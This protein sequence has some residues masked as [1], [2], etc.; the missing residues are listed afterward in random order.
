MNE[1]FITP[2]QLLESFSETNKI[3]MKRE[4]L[5][6]FSFG[7]NKVRIA[8]S[9]IKDMK[10]RG[11]DSIITYGSS[12]SNLSRVMANLCQ[13]DD[14]PCYVVSSGNEKEDNYNSK[15]IQLFNTEVIKCNK[16]N[17]ADTIK[18]LKQSLKDKGLNPYYVYGNIYGQGNEKTAVKPYKK[19]YEKIL[20][21]EDKMNVE[22]DYIFL[23]CGTGMTLSGLLSGLI[24]N[25]NHKKVIGISI[26]RKK[27]REEKIIKNYINCYF[28]NSIGKS[29]SSIISVVDDYILEG[30]GEYNQEI[31]DMIKKMMSKEGIPLD[32]IYTG[33]AFWGMK[34]YLQVNNIYNKNILFIN[35]G[36]NPLFFDYLPL[37]TGGER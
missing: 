19:V 36:G 27:R 13:K 34:N 8:K 2:I 5:L 29:L 33:K 25:E 17:V 35:T 14:I 7:G 31:I 28:N 21:Q 6:P 24:V 37:I 4:D 16:S 20:T 11:F 3:Y 22:F 12:K 26:S 18:K 23:A 15:L 9:F 32:P 1:K 30:Y 10:K